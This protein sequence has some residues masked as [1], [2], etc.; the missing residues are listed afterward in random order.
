MVEIKHPLWSLGMFL[1]GLTMN[2]N[3]DCL[4]VIENIECLLIKHLSD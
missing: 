2:K 4:L 1:F 3:I